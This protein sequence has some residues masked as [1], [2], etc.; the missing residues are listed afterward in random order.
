MDYPVR[1][2]TWR[3][4]DLERA[5]EWVTWLS[6]MSVWNVRKQTVLQEIIMLNFSHY[7]IFSFLEKRDRQHPKAIHHTK[8]RKTWLTHTFRP[9]GVSSTFVESYN[10]QYCF[11]QIHTSI[12]STSRLYIII[13]W[14]SS[15]LPSRLT[16]GLKVPLAQM[17][18]RSHSDSPFHSDAP[19]TIRNAPRTFHL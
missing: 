16:V 2:R 8:D 5:V 7:I 11:L 6:I 19:R 17:K 9:W 1:V 15:Q 14:A 3:Q 13:P 4:G 12:T 10:M 18:T